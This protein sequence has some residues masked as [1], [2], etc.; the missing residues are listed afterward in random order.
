MEDFWDSD[1]KTP[2]TQKPCSVSTQLFNS[3]HILAVLE[4]PGLLTLDFWFWLL[5]LKQDYYY[6]QTELLSE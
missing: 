1:S 2:L 3:S 6:T 5:I 4:V